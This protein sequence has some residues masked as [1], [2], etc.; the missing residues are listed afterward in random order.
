ME[1]TKERVKVRSAASTEVATGSRELGDQIVRLMAALT[2]AEQGSHPASAP[3]SPR[4]RGHG[5]GWADRSTPTHPSSHNGQTGLGQ[6]ASTHSSSAAS[7][8]STDSPR[9][10]NTWAQN[11]AWVVLRAQGTPTHCNASDAR[12]GVIWQGNVPLQQKH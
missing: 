12:V 7:R 2:R 8:E 4:H 10:G 1:E 9:R 6:T 5:R 11:G 3:N